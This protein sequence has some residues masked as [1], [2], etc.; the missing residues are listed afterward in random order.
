MY[1]H[2][3]NSHSFPSVLFAILSFLSTQRLF[4]GHG[5]SS[6][7]YASSHLSG[8]EEIRESQSQSELEEDNYAAQY[9]HM[10]LKQLRKETA[11]LQQWIVT[12][13]CCRERE[14]D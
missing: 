14:I 8:M 9:K 10:N 5:D 7:G 11:R 1:V 12:C 4:N 6:D 2:S 3:A 13:V